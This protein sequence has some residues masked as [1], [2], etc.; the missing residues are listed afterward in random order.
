VVAGT[1]AQLPIHLPQLRAAQSGFA[2]RPPGGPQTSDAG[3]PPLLIPAADA[4]TADL[5]LMCDL[6]L[7]LA[8]LK[9]AGGLLAS[10]FQCFK[11]PPWADELFHG[12]TIHHPRAFV[13]VLYEFQ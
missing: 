13:T 8:A 5:Q 10:G 11:I 2:P 9:G 6:G 3:A 12:A 7:S 1:L 4:L